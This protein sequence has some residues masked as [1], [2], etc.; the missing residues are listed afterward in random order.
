MALK[1][2]IFKAKI[3]VSDLNRDYYDT[4]QLTIAQHPSETLERMMIRVLAFCLNA[5]PQLRF[6][7]GL[8]AVEEPDIIARSLDDTLLTWIDVGEPSVDRVKKATTLANTVT[9]YS[10]NNKSPVWWKQNGQEMSKLSA[11]ICQVDWA[12][13]QALAKKVERTM[14]MSVTISEESAYFSFASGEC[15]VKWTNL[16]WP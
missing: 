7:K 11:T 1:P 3:S 4:I 12:D 10:F 2:T 13:A 16:A 5:D 14:D 8:S 15:E 6:T 9:I